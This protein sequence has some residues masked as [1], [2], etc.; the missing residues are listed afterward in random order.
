MRKVI[1]LQNAWSPEWAGRQWPRDQWLKELVKCRSGQ[2]VKLLTRDLAGEVFN[3]TPLVTAKASG[4]PP[5]DKGHV[6]R[7]LLD[8]RPELV[9]CCGEQAIKVV[10]EL[11]PGMRLELPHPACRWLPMKLYIEARAVIDLLAAGLM[12]PG[13]YRVW[14]RKGKEVKTE[15]VKQ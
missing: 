11:W 5:A 1:M 15:R 7:V 6:A 13:S 14:Q 10:S 12:E 8:K 9:V 2:M 4:K 3:T